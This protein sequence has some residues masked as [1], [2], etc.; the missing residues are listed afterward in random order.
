LGGQ[1][2]VIQLKHTVRSFN[3]EYF[4]TSIMTILGVK[5]DDLGVKIAIS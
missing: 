1:K 5:K 3:D 4:N 2:A